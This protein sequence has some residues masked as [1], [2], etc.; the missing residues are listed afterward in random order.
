MVDDMDAIPAVD[1]L[2]RS[3]EETSE[4]DLDRVRAA[5]ELAD[6]LGTLGDEVVSVGCVDAVTHAPADQDFGVA[7][8]QE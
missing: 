5:V 2:V 1:E 4:T 7:F 6:E 8:G 3:I